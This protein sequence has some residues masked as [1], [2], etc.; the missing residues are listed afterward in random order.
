MKNPTTLEFAGNMLAYKDNLKSL[1]DS[2]RDVESQVDDNLQQ[3]LIKS[4]SLIK[5]SKDIKEIELMSQALVDLPNDYNQ[6][7]KKKL[8]I[9]LRHMVFESQCMLIKEVQK[10]LLKAAEAMTD[11][12]N[13]ITLMSDF[14]IMIKALDKMNEKVKNT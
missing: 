9:S 7:S 12:G 2:I 13:G 4:S 3:A 10:S 5:L 14:N 6:L 11:A 1:T 8:L